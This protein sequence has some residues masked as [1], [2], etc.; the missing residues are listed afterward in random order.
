MSNIKKSVWLRK[1]VPI[2]NFKAKPYAGIDVGKEK[3]GVSKNIFSL[4]HL[5]I[6]LLKQ[7]NKLHA[8]GA[9]ASLSYKTSAFVLIF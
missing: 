7:I 1:S 4:K 6:F 5:L 8:Y 2:L 3:R 9:A